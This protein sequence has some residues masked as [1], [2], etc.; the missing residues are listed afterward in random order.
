MTRRF[1]G[2]DDVVIVFEACNEEEGSRAERIAINF[3]ALHDND[4]IRVGLRNG[5]GEGIFDRGDY[6]KRSRTFVYLL[7]DRFDVNYPGFINNEPAF[8][9][10]NLQISEI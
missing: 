6:A 1:S 7:Y 2:C 5:H 3:F 4:E 9:G 8:F 10:G